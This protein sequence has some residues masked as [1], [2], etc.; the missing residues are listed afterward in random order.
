MT[1]LVLYD[2]ERVGRW[3]ADQVDQRSP[4]GAFN[5]FGIEKDGEIVSGVVI[6]QINGANAFC[7]IAISRPTRLLPQ[8]FYIVCDYC[9]RQLNLR[10]LTGMVPTNEP[11]TIAFDKHLGFEEEFI[12]KHGAPNAD[13]QVLVL[14]ADNCRWLPK[15]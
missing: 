3:V 6:H 9:F 7:H 11:K 10:R 1:N 12:M 4:W 2:R 8:L 15:E 5:A 14:W 13:M